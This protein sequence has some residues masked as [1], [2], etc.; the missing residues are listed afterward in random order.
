MSFNMLDTFCY[1]F[2]FSQHWQVLCYYIDLILLSVHTFNTI[3]LSPPFKKTGIEGLIVRSILIKTHIPFL[4]TL[5]CL[6][7]HTSFNYSFQE[8][9]IPNVFN[10]LSY[11]IKNSL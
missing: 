6:Q 1:L 4:I 10:R 5:F 2:L 3:C 8:I 9:L 11:N 7:F